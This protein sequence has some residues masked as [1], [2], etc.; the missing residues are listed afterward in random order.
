MLELKSVKIT[1]DSAGQVL[2]LYVGVRCYVC[3]AQIFVA[4]EIFQGMKQ[5][6]DMLYF[7]QVTTIPLGQSLG[8]SKVLK[9][10]VN[11]SSIYSGGTVN[12]NC[13]RVMFA[14]H[15]NNFIFSSHKFKSLFNQND[16]FKKL[17][18]YI[19]KVMSVKDGFL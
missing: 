4:E 17:H 12:I 16:Y 6:S 14:L 9:T 5:I 7:K 10:F 19:R 11:P 1:D 18:I 8:L 15:S 3:V 2:E 13:S